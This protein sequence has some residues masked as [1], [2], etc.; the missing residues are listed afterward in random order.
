M[1]A[2]NRE[3][4]KNRAVVV[5][6]VRTPFVRAFGKLMKMDTIALGMAAVRGL[7]DRIHVDP[8]QID[9]VIWGG[10]I[11]PGDAANIGREIVMDAGLP[12]TI[13][14]TT[15]SR[16]CTSSLY[17]IT[18][19]VAA[20]ERGEADVIL[21]GG[22]DSTSNA[23]IKMPQSFV[24]KVAPVTMSSK[25]GPSDY[26]RLIT[27]LRPGRDLIPRQPS[28]KDRTTGLL[29]GEAAERMAS[30]N[31]ISREDQDAFAFQSHQ[32]A[33]QAVDMGRFQEEIVP[34]YLPNG[35]KVE[36]DDVIRADTSVEKLARLKPAFQKGGTLTAGNSSSL[37]DGA[38]CTL[39]AS[40]SKA[41]AMGWIPKAAFLSWSYDAVDP[42][43]QMLLGPAFS[44]P[45][46]MSRAGLSLKDIDVV[47]I[48]E[49]FAAQ[50]LCVLKMLG[51]EK[52]ARERLGLDRA[53][54][55]ISPESINIHGGS[56][57]LGHPFAATGARMVNTMANELAHTEKSR[58]LLGICGAGGVS[59]AAV[60][61]AV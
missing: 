26:L 14:G 7:L 55:E 15:V 2:K 24:H 31:S 32:R 50:V 46:A 30:R 11:L 56:I 59:A 38:A 19:A 47:D 13:E 35:R 53:V 16:A 5:S 39:I 10:V 27:R 36:T 54:G 34:V 8:Q 25:S 28:V 58:C 48:H 57:A 23:E 42:A 52:F 44:M 29:M 37:T 12:R 22:S 1:A 60:M 21:A 20:I 4:N 33:A 49:A 9:S 17:A 51:S 43:D 18:L 40:E 6:G 41:K 61:E 45:K 3:T